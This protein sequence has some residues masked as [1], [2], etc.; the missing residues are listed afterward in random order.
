VEGA[1]KEEPYPYRISGIVFGERGV[2]GLRLTNSRD[3]E[4]RRVLALRQGCGRM[5]M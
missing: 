5:E 4:S 2:E 1:N 3:C